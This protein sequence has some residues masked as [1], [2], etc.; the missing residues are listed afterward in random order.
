MKQVI[1]NIENIKWEDADNAKKQDFPQ[2]FIRRPFEMDDDQNVEGYIANWLADN[3][4]KHNGFD[5]KIVEEY[6]S[7][8]IEDVLEGIEIEDINELD[9]D[10]LQKQI[11]KGMPGYEIEI[12]DVEDFPYSLEMGGEVATVM[13][14]YAQQ[15][16]IEE[17]KVG[18][19]NTLSEDVFVLVV[20]I[21]LKK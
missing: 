15:G 7:P 21:K 8:F 5:L 12:F 3:Y 16:A 19:W 9:W 10:D 18:N 14:R 11:E 1:V 4:D 2:A 6:Y 20:A 13:G 17:V